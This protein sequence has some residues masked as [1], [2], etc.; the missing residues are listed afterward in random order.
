MYPKT[1]DVVWNTPGPDVTG[2]MPLGNGDVGLNLW[3]EPDGDLLFYISKSDA[4]SDSC[5]LIKV[6]RVR[7]SFS[8]NPFRTGQ[9]FRQAL[10]LADGEIE[11]RA[12]GM[13]ILAR[14]DA[15]HPL[16]RIEASATRPFAM[17]ARLEV[18]R[19]LPRPFRQ[20]EY[21]SAWFHG[22]TGR[23]K[24]VLVQQPDTLVRGLPDRVAWYQRNE[25]SLW[26]GTLR[27][28][29]LPGWIPRAEDPLLHRTFGGAMFGDNLR[30]FDDVTLVSAKRRRS[31]TLSISVLTARTP[32]ADEWLQQLD[33]LVVAARRLK[34]VPARQAHRAWWGSFW[35]RSRIH[36]GGSEEATLVSRGYTLQRYMQAAAGRGAYPLKFNGSIF[37]VDA[38]SSERSIGGPGPLQPSAA[39]PDPGSAPFE[40]DAD[41]R[42]WGGPYWH[43]NTRLPYWSML[44]SGDFD[45]MG[46]FFRMYRESQPFAEY[47]CR[48]YYGHPGAF[49]PETMYFWGGY[50]DADYGWERA[51]KPVGEA[52]NPYIRWHWQGAIEVLSTMIEFHAHTGDETFAR[53][54]MLP[55]AVSVIEFF[56]RHYSRDERG[57]LKIEPSQALETWQDA[58]NPLPEVAGL[59]WV[60]GR[61]L[62]LPAALLGAHRGG[63]E[64]FCGELP[65]VPLRE[66][67]GQRFLAPAARFEQPKNRE[68]PELYAI[69]P[70]PIYGVGKP[71]L[72]MARVSFGVRK[73]KGIGGWSQDG[74]QAACLGLTEVAGAYAVEAATMRHSGSRFPAFW[75]PNYDWVPDQDHGSALMLA[76]QKMLLQTDG[77]RILLFPAWPRD[78][79][80][81]FKLHAPGRTVVEGRYRNGKLD[82]LKVIPAKRRK[83]V[84]LLLPV[85]A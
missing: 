19:T 6:G 5:R 12:G 68:I 28:Q 45:L 66:E 69:F 72:E 47:R 8:P 50:A 17:T 24:G 60:L 75:G 2:S 82:R 34:A 29:D 52:A 44:P 64:R 16:V 27:N 80:V 36:I 4:W 23:P 55:F 81:D 3:I 46:P 85:S 73:F 21:H 62:A 10:R 59:R 51:G 57:A 40:L 56:D 43:Q 49:W 42:R 25:E 79:D 39:C 77:E 83:D 61:L 1:H 63:W 15:H 84:T 54:T 9:P 58:T 65:P 71:D 31:Q 38:R 41:Y 35:A 13:T 32:T 18:W 74:I 11:I 53:G 67:N 78:W 26:A 76:V 70:Y 22:M 48:E 20:E 30:K 33:T 37:N 7:V 14:V